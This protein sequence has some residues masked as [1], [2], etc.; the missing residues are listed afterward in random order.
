MDYISSMINILR[1][2]QVLTP[3]QKDILDTWNESQKY[4]F[5]MQAARRQILMN[6]YNHLELIEKTAGVLFVMQKP[7][8]QIGEND[9]RRILNTQLMCLIEKERETRYYGK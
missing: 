2:M 4:P 5:D 6:V 3:L 7:P 8:Q 1:L 9:F